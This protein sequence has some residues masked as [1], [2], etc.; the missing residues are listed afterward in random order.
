MR[1]NRS[2]VTALVLFAAHCL[3]SSLRVGAA[4]QAAAG[5]NTTSGPTTAVAASSRAKPAFYI[6]AEFTQSLNAKKL[7]PGD[8]IK[9]QVTQDVLSHG[10]IIIPVASR[11]IGHVTE[12]KVHQTD[13]P[14]SRLGIV[15]DKVLLRHPR[16]VNFVGVVQTLGAPATRRSKADEPDPM[17]PMDASS[18]GQPMTIGTGPASTRGTVYPGPS[19]SNVATNPAGVPTFLPP[20][21]SSDVSSSPHGGRP[22]T[23]V[24]EHKPMSVGTPLGV[25]GLKGLSLI[26]GTSSSTPGPVIR[27]RAG[28]V[29]LENGTQI[30]LRVTDVTVLQP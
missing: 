3:G 17:L 4:Q 22:L 20:P 26:P 28:D 30:L 14:E 6:L 16:E 9:A 7:K 5:G 11:L 24:E 25:Y 2:I 19:K 12:V 29:K 18:K 13:D 23:P 27:S 21:S 10:R 1:K 15:F 8:P